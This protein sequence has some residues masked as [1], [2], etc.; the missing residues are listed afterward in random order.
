MNELDWIKRMQQN[1]RILHGYE[2]ILKDEIIRLHTLTWYEKECILQQLEAINSIINNVLQDINSLVENP[3]EYISMEKNNKK[4][5][6]QSVR[7]QSP[8]LYTSYFDYINSS[9][10][11]K[12]YMEKK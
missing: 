7:K 3:G 4:I 12:R 9:F 2:Y 1:V 11:R 10:Q 8:M 6:K 5:L